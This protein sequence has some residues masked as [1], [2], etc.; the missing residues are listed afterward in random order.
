M[1][2]PG[3]LTSGLAYVLLRL[4]MPHALGTVALA[5]NVLGAQIKRATAPSARQVLAPFH[6]VNRNRDRA[7]ASRTEDVDQGLIRPLD[8]LL[9]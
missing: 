6:P 5:L 8:P 1:G 3:S 7:A 4:G 9:H 2:S